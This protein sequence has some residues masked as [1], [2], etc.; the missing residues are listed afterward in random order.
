MNK[1][2]KLL[3]GMVVMLIFM[4]VA[5]FNLQ[6]GAKIGNLSDFA[7]ANIEALANNEQPT[8]G[9]YTINDFYGEPENCGYGAIVLTC[10]CY[11][12]DCQSVGDIDGTCVKG[13]IT[14]YFDCYMNKLDEEVC[15]YLTTC[16][17]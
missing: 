6:L 2:L 4:A 9:C 7:L 5:T 10:Q 16:L 8:P 13:T 15:I 11:C 1:K 3:F 14:Y 17:D 12:Y